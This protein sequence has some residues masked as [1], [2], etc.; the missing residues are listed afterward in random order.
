MDYQLTFTIGTDGTQPALNKG[1]RSVTSR[2]RAAR[3]SPD[4]AHTITLTHHDR[5]RARRR[6]HGRGT[7]PY[8][9][10]RI[11]VRNLGP[12]EA[13]G[14]KICDR[15]RLQ[16]PEVCRR[17]R[18]RRRAGA[19]QRCTYRRLRRRSRELRVDSQS[20]CL[21][22]DQAR[23]TRRLTSRVRATYAMRRKR[24]CRTAAARLSAYPAG[25][26]AVSPVADGGIS[27]ESSVSGTAPVATRV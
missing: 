25:P 9:G 21:R 16:Q 18:A 8:R 11:V 20:L 22:F 24:S 5:R 4:T 13:P 10:R 23:Q 1:R 3:K 15:T 6:S 17:R 26:C 27:A 7:D 12:A 14:R 19:E 2:A